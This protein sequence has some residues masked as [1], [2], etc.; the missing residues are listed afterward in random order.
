MVFL[1]SIPCA[2]KSRRRRGR[3]CGCST[4]SRR[5]HWEGVK[6]DKS[7]PVTKLTFC[8]QQQ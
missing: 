4:R 8:F 6:R 1:K 2:I 5:R 7:H 3:G